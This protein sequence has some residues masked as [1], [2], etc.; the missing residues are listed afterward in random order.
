MR[1]ISA[2]KFTAFIF[3]LFVC[4]FISGTVWSI[5]IGG[6]QA[7][8]W[9]RN[10]SPYIITSDI[11]V[12]T[13]MTLSIESGVVV[14][15]A[16]YYGIKVNGTLKALGIV[17]ERIVFT[18][19][20]DKE[21]GVTDQ[22]TTI[23]PSNRDWA[24]IEFTPSSGNTSELD[25][26]IIRYTDKAILSNYAN[27]SLTNI[28][29]VDC[30]AHNLNINGQNISIREGSEQNYNVVQRTVSPPTQISPTPTLTPEPSRETTPSRSNQRHSAL[31]D[32]KLFS[33]EEFTFGEIKVISAAKIEQTPEEAPSSIY[34]IT[35]AEILANG[36]ESLDEILNFIPGFESMI[37][38]G[39]DNLYNVRGIGS[40]FN[41]RILF[42]IDGISVA[43]AFHGGSSRSAKSFSVANI[44]QIEIIT[45]PGSA[46][47][48]A[49]AFSGIVNIIMK[50]ADRSGLG[51]KFCGGD[52]GALGA[53]SYVS[54]KNE[55]VGIR[56]YANY[57]KD[58]G[59]E[60]AYDAYDADRNN[61]IDPQNMEYFCGK[62][63]MLKYFTLSL[64]YGKHTREDGIGLNFPHAAQDMEV[65][66]EYQNISL[67]G[68][69]P[70]SKRMHLYT[71]LY[72]RKANWV[73][74]GDVLSPEQMAVHPK[75]K[76]AYAA[77]KYPDGGYF[78]PLRR[79]TLY[80]TDIYTNFR[81]SENLELLFGV[82]MEVT[83]VSVMKL[84]VLSELNLPKVPALSD[85]RNHDLAE[86]VL[87]D[88]TENR[89][90]YAGYAQATIHLSN[91]S[92][93]IGRRYDEYS[94]IGGTL[95]P[96][97]GIVYKPK[98]SFIIKLLSGQ[99]F[100]APAIRDLYAFKAGIPV[101]GNLAFAD[102]SW[103]EELGPEISQTYELITILKP[104]PSTQ[105]EFNGSYIRITDIIFENNTTPVAYYNNAGEATS[106]GASLSLRTKLSSRFRLNTNF[107]Y[108]QTKTI[109]IPISDDSEDGQGTITMDN[110][111]M[112]PI[113]FNLWGDFDIS[114]YI[115]FA[116]GLNYRSA[117]KRG[118][119]AAD[120]L[121]L[122]DPRKDVPA[123][124]V[125][126]L[127]M[128]IHKI[129]G[130]TINFGA[131]DVLDSK[132]LDPGPYPL[133]SASSEEAGDLPNRGRTLYANIKYEL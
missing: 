91:I 53:C 66:G 73:G 92:F 76:S 83:D 107:G 50:K 10:E 11:I 70:I 133:P 97:T 47:Y 80:G 4:Y 111:L 96:R 85:Q 99:A 119:Y 5:E 3:V 90:I 79:S 98:E 32:D 101:S 49:G 35:R 72:H 48:G 89:I 106:I 113:L 14:K 94:D 55:N 109:D 127:N 84:G 93:L 69:F 23:L 1:S 36:W 13:G 95:N 126:N 108:Y 59:F 25:H 44:D 2:T 112:S 8:I 16:D 110:M 37:T 56:L 130:I 122:E 42:M 82:A 17:R 62:I 19:I 129:G 74:E 67:D 27:P 58:D 24:G 20:H 120:G 18:S 114:K 15:F 118:L 45:G 54:Y 88:G 132:Y 124:T 33:E 65:Y 81:A 87:L 61:I 22:P 21:F 104:N 77:G 9:T 31:I 51:I 12:P 105:I 6:P 46:L 40:P 30:N 39:S 57:K 29:I 64:N 7:G 75:F 102:S 78:E 123:Y 52:G 86:S 60:R 121:D 125:I 71:L 117:K 43:D 38:A 100:R 103:Y 41:S 68:S 63:N 28:I 116:F 115:K 131:K 34:T 128:M 26:C